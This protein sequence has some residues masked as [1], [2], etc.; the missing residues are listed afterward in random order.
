MERTPP[1]VPLAFLDDYNLREALEAAQEQLVN[2]LGERER[3]EWKIN[4]LQNDIVH[5]AALCRVEV[6][7]PIRQLGLTDAV[8]WI[9]ASEKHKS[10]NIKQVVETLQQSWTDASTYKNLQANVNTIFRRLKKS[11]EITL[12]TEVPQYPPGRL[13]KIGDDDE[14]R[15]IWSGGLPPLPPYLKLTRK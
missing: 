6:E 5:L 10:L 15:Y 8:R 2:L 14:D 13:S 12:V 7:E 3:M 11:G 9:F 4:K 1:L